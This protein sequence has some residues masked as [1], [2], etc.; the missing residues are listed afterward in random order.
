M[1]KY[2]EILS[3]TPLFRGIARE[4]LSGLLGCLGARTEAFSKGDP[5]FL[6][7]DPAGFIGL[8][9]EGT[10]E[11]V[12]DDF[13]G[14]RS[15]LTLAQPGELFAEAFAC[16][17]AEAMPVS[18]YAARSS[19]VMW[20]ECRNMI[21]TCSNSC[22]FHNVLVK[23]LLQV[24]ARK[25]LQLSRKIQF[26]SRK[27]TREKLMEYLLDQAKQQ[28]SPEFEIPLNRQALAD[29]LGVERS[30]MSAELGKLRRAGVLESTGSHF[31]LLEP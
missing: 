19:L 1:E 25:N 13:Y 18:G 4:K 23:N 24:M 2:F 31:R 10:V 27:T 22:V 5:V 17:G 7:G 11:I 15:L 21:T 9:L 28:K 8:V 12:R 16:A 14:N 6:E 30:A 3:D 29:F 20:M 26:M